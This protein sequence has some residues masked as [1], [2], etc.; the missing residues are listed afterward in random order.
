MGARGWKQRSLF[1]YIINSTRWNGGEYNAILISV[2]IIQGHNWV[3][4]Q[5]QTFAAILHIVALPWRK[6]E[7]H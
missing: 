1:P 7:S 4:S 2:R 3:D 6:A 5:S